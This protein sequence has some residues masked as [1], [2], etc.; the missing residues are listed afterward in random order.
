MDIDSNSVIFYTDKNNNMYIHKFIFLHCNFFQVRNG[1]HFLKALPV[2]EK[3]MFEILYLKI[4]VNYHCLA[5]KKTFPLI[6]RSL[7]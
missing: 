6:Y 5:E 2:F 3:T 4:N 7:L 1:D